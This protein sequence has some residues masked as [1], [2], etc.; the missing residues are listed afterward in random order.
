MGLNSADSHSYLQRETKQREN[1]TVVKFLRL[2]EK[3]SP[4]FICKQ[5]KSLRDQLREIMVLDTE[6]VRNVRSLLTCN[7]LGHGEGADCEVLTDM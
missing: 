1:P 3:S 5:T 2:K 4:L 7:C 6:R